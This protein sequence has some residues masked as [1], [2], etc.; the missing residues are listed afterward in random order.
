MASYTRQSTFSDGDLITAALFNDEYNQLVGAFDNAT[1]HRHDGTV[2]EGPVISVLGDAGLSTPLNKILVDTT[3]D[4]IEFY[5]D[6]SGTSTQQLY[7]ADGAIVPTTN[8]DID[9]GT[10]ASKFKDLYLSG[11]ANITGNA[12]VTGNL[13]VE[14]TTVT[15]NT[16]TLDV[17]DKNITLNYGTGDT[18]SNADGAGITIQD[19]VDA[20]TD[21][22]ILWN[23]TN[24]RF[25][26]SHAID[27]TGSAT[28]DGLTLDGTTFNF[29]KTTSGLG[30]IYFNDASNNGSAVLSSG[31]NAQALRLWTDRT[32]ASNF[33]YLEVVDG[34]SAKRLLLVDDSGDI[35]FYEDTGTTAKFFWDASAESL[36]IGT[37][38]L[39][40][41]LT[42]DAG[43]IALDDNR[44]VTWGSNTGRVKI[45]GNESLDDIRFN[46]DNSERMRLTNT[47]LGIGTTAPSSTLDV[48]GTIT[49]G[50]LSDGTITITGFVDEDNMSSNSA[51]LVPTQQ[52]VKAYVDAQISSAGDDGISFA[53]NEKAKF[54]DSNDLEIF[55]D[56][57]NSYIKDV[58]TG[59]LW[60][61]GVNVHLGNP[62]ASE[63]Y[64]Q[65]ISNGAVTLYYDN[66]AKLATTS[67]GV[68]ITGNATFD[69]NGKAI[70]GTDSD[71]QIYHDGNN[72]Y[73]AESGTGSLLISGGAN[74]K[75][76]SP[77]DED[78]IIATAN[79]AVTLYHN[80]SPK[81]ATTS[82]GIDVTGT[83]V[84][85]GLTVNSGDTSSFLT[86]RN[87]SN[88][89]FTKLYSDLNGVTVLDVDANN[90]GSSPRFQIDV[91]E[92][93][94]L[95]ITEGGDIAF[96]D[97]TGTSQNMVWD[98]S[99]DSL[100][101]VDNAKATFGASNDLQIYHDGS[102][103][104]IKENGTGN[105]YLQGTSLIISN[106][107]G[108]NYLVAYDG[109]SVNLYHNANPK[110]ATTSSGVNV[111]GTAT[112]DGL[113]VDGN[114]LLNVE[115]NELQFNTSSTPV[116]K[117][118]TDDTYTANGLTISAD[119]GVALESTNN[120]LLLDDTGTNEMVLNVDGGE[121]MRVTSTGIDVTGTVVSDGLTVQT[122]QGD[123]AIA[124]SASSLNFARAGT[125]YIRATDSA[126]HF[127]FITGAN[128]FATQRLNIAANGDISFYD[129]TGSTQG[130]FWDASAESLGIGTT[131]PSAKLHVE[132]AN[133]YNGTNFESNPHLVIDN[134]TPTNHTAVLMFESS[135]TDAS[136]K[137][138]GITGGNYYS[139]KHG[140]GFFGDLAS[141]DRSATPDMFV[142]SSGNV[143]IGT[144][145]PSEAL[146]VSG[147][148]ELGSAN[149][150]YL[151]NGGYDGVGTHAAI[152]WFSTGS[153]KRKAAD[154]ITA[155]ADSFARSDL[156][157]RT[158]SGTANADPTEVMRITHD[159]RVGIGTTSP[160]SVL[161]IADSGVELKITDTRNQSF[162]VGD[163]I[164]T[165]GF[166][167][168]DASG[169]SGAA[170]N[171]PRGAID[172][173]TAS[174][175]GSAHDM[176]FRTRAD[177]SATASEKLRITS[178]GNVGIAGATTI[179]D[180][181]LQIGDSDADFNI[182]VAGARSKFGYDSS[183]NSAVV[184]GGV[185]K[186]IIFCVN[187]STLGS[188][189]VGRF[190]SSGNFGIGTTTP[191]ST[192][193]VDGTINN[194]A[195]KANETDFSDSILIS[196]TGATGT[197]SASQNNTGLGNNV[198]TDLTTADNST[199]IGES[200]L[201]NLTTGSNNT[202]IGSGTLS[203]VTTSSGN[204]AVG[205]SALA[206]NTAAENT[207]VGKDAGRSN[208]TGA[209]L[210]AIGFEA[211][212]LNTTGDSNTAVGYE[213]MNQNT[214]GIRN[215]AV[216]QQ[217]L[218]NNTT[219][220]ENTAVGVQALF[221]N[222]TG[223][224]NVAIGYDCL[225]ANTTGTNNVSIGSWAMKENETGNAN[226]AIGRYAL[227]LNTTGGNNV[228]IGYEALTSA[229][230]KSGQTAVG[231]QSLKNNTTGAANVG[232]GYRTLFD[233]TTGSYNVAIGVSALENSTTANNNT[234]V[235]YQA[236]QNVTTGSQIT[237]IGYGAADAI[238]DA[239]SATAVGWHCLG[240]ATVRGTG[241]GAYCLS[242]LTTG[243]N[244]V[245]FGY[246]AMNA[247]S[248][249][250]SNAAF[251][252]SAMQQNTTGSSN[253]AVGR[254][255]VQ[256]NT[257][258]TNNIGL[259]FQALK[260]NTIG[261]SNVGVGYQA[262]LNT[263]G[264]D[265]TVIGKSAGS[266]ITTGSRNTII[267][268]FDGNQ[269]GLDI[270]T[271]NN[272]IVLSDGDGNPRQVIDSS[273]NLLVG[274]TA[275]NNNDVGTTIYNSA[276]VSVVRSSGVPLILN[277]KTNDG[278]ILEIRKDG[279]AVGSIG[280]GSGNIAL[281]IG[282][283]EASAINNSFIEFRVDGSQKAQLNA[284]G[285]F[286]VGTTTGQ[287]TNSDITTRAAISGD[288]YL[289]GVRFNTGTSEAAQT[290]ISSKLWMDGS[291]LYIGSVV[292]ETGAT[293]DRRLKENIEN[294]PNAIEKVKL[295]NGVTYNY[296][297]KP[298]V[299][300]A[301][302]I[303]QDVEKALPEAVYTAYEDG[304]EVLALKYNRITSV[305][306][307]AMK[308]QQE[309]IESLKSE[310][311]KLKGE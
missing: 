40:E 121:R 51:T 67:T 257:T 218:K 152:R 161:E 200:A 203:D 165:L 220:N 30:G 23:A 219:A 132:S 306:V 3:N 2:G 309:Q 129:D 240:N 6:V 148:A 103:S 222:T 130:L 274:K 57:S 68:A 245:A 36:G 157:F 234:A 271:S 150:L 107:V 181:N 228:A 146:S 294:I 295:L 75:I 260:N 32:D 12:V 254:Q 73:I 61:G 214:T 237:A 45:S 154:I 37:T 177:T 91:S 243:A 13:T 215:V 142:N 62:T 278:T 122:A 193:T 283:D 149:N 35:S 118:Y 116:N 99:A 206:N 34:A 127:K 76:Q 300:E 189:E 256:S 22:T 55:H 101:F 186:G 138:S 87:G 247:T 213:A 199:A 15:L 185:T 262:L 16:A 281:R 81:I 270:R 290:V 31:S 179:D 58:G 183:N 111:T 4:H 44:Y 156:L 143:G 21:A 190:D 167:S 296:K 298:N 147:N 269:G 85:D 311:K 18:S 287:T 110:L 52:S 26:F 303:A 48:N 11:T 239:G 92:V 291:D 17:E 145:S 172:M 124:N 275:A 108:A 204:T 54:G 94:A 284:A 50:S 126:G 168:D 134:G 307:E 253:V 71:L 100:N 105:L 59:N 246:Y 25:D 20:S 102:N 261:N 229:T 192:L 267:G 78:M 160:S 272:H 235:G 187:N 120:Y 293:S 304:E 305:L 96:Y 93:Q 123:I 268:Q 53:D 89:S 29:N 217:A 198:L 212:E 211:L 223:N 162:T 74:V 195:I 98:A 1:G 86:I 244:N 113:T 66:S 264:Y 49:Y 19:A 175:F 263:T 196:T 60:I 159:N 258:G 33:G 77:S 173:V 277:R 176:V 227:E 137:R 202:A 180:G 112:M 153:A 117:I 47:G 7:I 182:A 265:N 238:T 252:D 197:L 299:K 38:S 216:G 79:G 128:D 169:S 125:N 301:G 82:T 72:S 151:N 308:E 63:Y 188:G 302:F 8:D 135:G 69:D 131:S 205:V 221:L 136:N 141:K 209:K 310:I 84:T 170:N 119:N 286:Y 171:L 250:A 24:D 10:S 194:V 139:N 184:Q 64:I 140:L 65:T 14:G 42:V 106:S 80:N 231:Y 280:A 232:L 164:T 292:I 207:A 97:N 255:A 273:G 224:N 241:L 163:I 43:N 144:D 46:T 191:T 104:Y 289:N 155:Q 236:A 166:Y 83:T 174:T 242:A 288:V 201:A 5:I 9:L 282:V 115:G 41:K 95:R 114:I 88:S 109:G 28:V 226:I 133:N 210:T 178:S 248:T 230:D 251:G 70:F 208:T 285:N 259:G 56:G 297:K 225:E 249:G 158:Q 276:G 27:V 233:N 90:V 39:T 279:T 266:L